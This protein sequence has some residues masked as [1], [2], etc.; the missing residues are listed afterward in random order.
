MWWTAWVVTTQQLEPRDVEWVLGHTIYVPKGTTQSP[1]W[2]I[3]IDGTARAPNGGPQLDLF[4]MIAAMG[5]QAKPMPRVEVELRGLDYTER[6]PEHWITNMTAGLSRG[7][8]KAKLRSFVT[9]NYYDRAELKLPDVPPQ[10][11][12]IHGGEGEVGVTRRTG[13]LNR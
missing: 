12:S 1:K 11:V 2:W 8:R 3:P 5:P 6:M 9:M 7:L 10:I 4:V 13:C